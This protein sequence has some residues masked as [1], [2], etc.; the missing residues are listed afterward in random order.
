M[1]PVHRLAEALE[2]GGTE[3]DHTYYEDDGDSQLLGKPGKEVRRAD[4]STWPASVPSYSGPP[5][6]A[7]V[8]WV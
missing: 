2:E 3:P 6:A 4:W 8:G 7:A 1:C 5:T